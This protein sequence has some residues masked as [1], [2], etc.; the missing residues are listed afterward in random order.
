MRTVTLEEHFVTES[1]LR[2][3]GVPLLPR[4]WP[5]SEELQPKLLDL[6][7]GRIA[8]MDEASIDFQVLSLCSAIRLDTIHAATVRAD[9]AVRPQVSTP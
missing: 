5:Q 4:V 7:A 2:A 6:G 1:S 9:R 8:A 3:T